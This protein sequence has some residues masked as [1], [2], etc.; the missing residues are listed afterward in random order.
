[1]KV[2]LFSLLSALAIFSCQSPKPVQP[3]IL[4][5]YIR[6]DDQEGTITAEASLKTN[7][8]S[9][10]IPIEGGIFFQGNQMEIAPITHVT[11]KISYPAAFSDELSFRVGEPGTARIFTI[12]PRNIENPR[13]E[14]KSI[15]SGQPASLIWDGP[16]LAKGETLVLLWE[17]TETH[18]TIP[19]ELISEGSRPIIDFP[20]AQLKPLEKGTWSL[21]LVRKQLHKQTAE[22]IKASIIFE[23][24]TKAF[25]VMIK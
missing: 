13:F 17:N 2:T 8:Q 25:T 20:A 10:T 23:H 6:L 12:K 15:P 22:N 11:Y 14:N 21:Y 1:M 4:N 7:P 24:Y 19:M 5:A 9:P 16:P 18:Q 3:G